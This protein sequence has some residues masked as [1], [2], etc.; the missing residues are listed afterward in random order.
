MTQRERELAG[1]ELSLRE[2]LEWETTTVDE[3]VQLKCEDFWADQN[4]D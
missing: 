2:G 1:R 3:Q 4:P